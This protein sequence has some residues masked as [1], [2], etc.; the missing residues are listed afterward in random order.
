ME[1]IKLNNIE[2]FN[3]AKKLI[4][5]YNEGLTKKVTYVKST[6]EPDLT[7][8][9]TTYDEVELVIMANDVVKEILDDN[10]VI[11]IAPDRQTIIDTLT[12]AAEAS[13]LGV[14]FESFYYTNRK[15][16]IDWVINGGDSLLT[17]FQESK[18]P[19][20][21]MRE[22]KDSPSPREFALNLLT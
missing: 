19:W 16:I 7:K 22:D 18:E 14:P 9:Y 2:D 8:P 3:S 11:Y 13:G 20:L 1:E 4:E 21:D 17:V 6:V 10:S 15:L 12:D 5:E